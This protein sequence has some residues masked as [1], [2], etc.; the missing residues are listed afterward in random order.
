LVLYAAPRDGEDG[1]SR[2]GFV[3][4]RRIGNAVARNRVKRRLREAVRARYAGL[5]SGFDL[6]WIARPPIATA[7]FAAIGAGVDEVLRRARLFRAVSP[8]QGEPGARRS[9]ERAARGR[10][11]AGHA[12]SAALTT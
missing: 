11:P 3:V 1:P 6:V 4:G 5:A 12:D 10:S 9:A 2:S 8:G 7:E